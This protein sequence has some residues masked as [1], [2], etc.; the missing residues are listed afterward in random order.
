M[1]KFFAGAVMSL[2]LCSL[3]SFDKVFAEV[4]ICSPQN[5]TTKDSDRTDTIQIAWNAPLSSKDQPCTMPSKTINTYRVYLTSYTKDGEMLARSLYALPGRLTTTTLVL[6]PNTQYDVSVD[7]IYDDGS[8]SPS[9]TLPHLAL[10]DVNQRCSAVNYSASPEG[11]DGTVFLSWDELCNEGTVRPTGY[12]VWVDSGDGATGKYVLTVP[13]SGINY[14]ARV[15]LAPGTAYLTRVYTKYAN[16]VPEFA[17]V[18]VVTNGSKVTPVRT[19]ATV[20]PVTPVSFNSEVIKKAVSV[21]LTDMVLPGTKQNPLAFRVTSRNTVTNGVALRWNTPTLSNYPRAS[22]LKRYNIYYA[23]YGNDGQLSPIKL[24]TRLGLVNS[25]YFS[26]IKKDAFY[27]IILFARNSKDDTTIESVLDKVSLMDAKMPAENISPNVV[28]S[29]AFVSTQ[30]LSP[31]T[32]IDPWKQ[33]VIANNAQNSPYIS[34]SGVQTS[35]Y[36]STSDIKNLPTTTTGTYPQMAL[37]GSEL[38]ATAP[39]TTYPSSAS[40]APVLSINQQH[41]IIRGVVQSV[42]AGGTVIIKTLGGSWTVMISPQAVYTPNGQR[43]NISVDDYVGVDGE[44]SAT[45]DNYMTAMRVR[46][47]TLFP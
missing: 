22:L 2:C 5:L 15:K 46:N 42:N 39:I 14:S 45:L 35:S 38:T 32:V 10:T 34:T 19:V 4:L 18:N 47:R 16:S 24:F 11:E 26:P 28:T 9:V 44:I 37:N 12:R 25:Y 13:E 20:A 29:Q 1:K 41:I 6:A 21:P 3:L 7:V 43:Q 33:T 30:T 27:K 36:I 23:E 40:R 17:S 8:V 31:Y